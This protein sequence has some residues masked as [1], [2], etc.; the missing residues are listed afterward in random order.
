VRRLSE[1][2]SPISGSFVL[3]Y[4]HDYTSDIPFDSSESYLK[5]ELEKL[6]DVR[7]VS[8]R[9]YDEG[10]GL[11][12]IISFTGM[13]GNLR[14]SSEGGYPTPI[15]GHFRLSYLSQLTPILR[16]DA[17]AEEVKLSLESLEAVNLVDVVR[18]AADNGQFTWRIT[19]RN[20][21]EPELLKLDGGLLTGTVN[22]MIVQ[23]V[24]P[25]KNPSLI[26]S[27]SSNIVP[28]VVVQEVTSGLPS[29]TGRIN[30]NKTGIYCTSVL[31]LRRGGLVAWYYDNQWMLDETVMERVDSTVNF[32]W[33]SGRITQYGNDYVSVRWWGK[34]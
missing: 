13:Q 30:A 31:Q 18:I 1:G 25:A 34:V 14:L 6:P 9:K 5:I 32:D 20:P 8:V 33:G 24:V 17:S 11:N 23:R 12:W 19:F 10:N 16:F 15:G 7:E 3:A 28:K 29:Y 21:M 22:R 27:S 4:E 26:S 2:V